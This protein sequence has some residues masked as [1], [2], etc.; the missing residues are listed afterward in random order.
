MS[1]LKWRKQLRGTE[2]LATRKRASLQKQLD[3]IHSIL[4]PSDQG[5]LINGKQRQVS[6]LLKGCT[7][8]QA[9]NCI[10]QEC[11]STWMCSVPVGHSI[12]PYKAG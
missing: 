8:E 3:L 4:V 12:V 6:P 9:S 2:E 7:V 10:G 5:C 1:A 11:V